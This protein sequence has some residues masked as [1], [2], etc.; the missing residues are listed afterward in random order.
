[1]KL[2]SLPSLVA[3]IALPVISTSC[4][5][6]LTKNMQEMGY[7][8]AIPTPSRAYIGDL[9][10]STDL[11]NPH[12]LLENNFSEDQIAKF[13]PQRNLVNVPNSG[14]ESKWNITVDANVISSVKGALEANG[15]RTYKINFGDVYE[16]K[17]SDSY[18]ED[19]VFKNIRK[20]A[21]RRNFNGKYAIVGLLQVGS[22]TYDFYDSKGGKIEIQPGSDFA[23]QVTGKLGAG[24]QVTKNK[25]LSFNQPM[26]LGYRMAKLEGAAFSP[27]ASPQATSRPAPAAPPSG[28]FGAAPAVRELSVE[29]M[30]QISP[31][32]A[33]L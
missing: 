29:E 21:P 24:W 26:V 5:D 32:V 15:A 27:P 3:F 14:G 10:N 28:K 18:F 19:T 6:P 33:P 31:D 4:L 13:A 30:K 1:M 11:R 17:A 2:P 7:R 8:T 16:Y 20:K 22:L 9:Y 23:E 12:W 25:S